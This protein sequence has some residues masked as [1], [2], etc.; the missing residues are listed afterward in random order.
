MTYNLEK[1]NSLNGL[2]KISLVMDYL[3]T[4]T[5]INSRASS[6]TLEENMTI[7]GVDKQEFE[8]IVSRLVRDKVL[9][10]KKTIWHEIIKRDNDEFVIDASGTSYFITINHD[11]FADFYKKLTDR[12]RELKGEKS[13]TNRLDF[14]SAK[15][16]LYIDQHEIRVQKFS[17]QYHLL[18]IIFEDKKESLREWFFSEVIERYDS[19]DDSLKPKKF[20]NAVYQLN[21]KI[22]I[23]TGI[24]NFFIITN[25][26]FQ[27]NKEYL[28]NS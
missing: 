11:N 5:E 27:V 6:I 22:A 23:E 1:T 21:R 24:K 12:I 16:I 8:D 10:D 17:D 20:Y 15:A 3:M 26:V 28:N 9:K 7:T 25:Q 19:K 4:K 13:K 14:D 2:E 18:R